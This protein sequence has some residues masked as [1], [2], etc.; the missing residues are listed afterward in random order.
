MSTISRSGA[1][2]SLA[3]LN[4]TDPV[5]KQLRAVLPKVQLSD[6]RVVPLAGGS[7]SDVHKVTWINSPSKFPDGAVLRSVDEEGGEDEIGLTKWAG[8]QGLGPN[9][10][11]SDLVSRVLLLEFLPGGPIS[12]DPDIAIPLIASCLARLHT[13]SASFV[14]TMESNSEATDVDGEES[15]ELPSLLRNAKAVGAVARAAL[16]APG[17]TGVLC[18]RD[19]HRHNMMI[20]RGGSVKLIDWTYAKV[21]HPLT[22]VALVSLFWNFTEVQEKILLKEYLGSEPTTDLQRNFRL[23]K[24]VACL[25]QLDWGLNRCEG[26]AGLYGRLEETIALSDA[27]PFSSFAERIASGEGVGT[28]PD[29]GRM[30]AVA[31]ARLLIQMG[32]EGE[33]A[34]LN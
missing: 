27:P 11:E 34:A 31:A 16:W 29:E 7:M 22:D 8:D 3:P 5:A 21:D 19:L 13:E 1:D 33:G 4:P 18:H 6:C 24:R 14:A 25:S 30:Y 32:E 12:E 10:L 17:G 15:V 2:A 20:S 26:D 23:A 9:V 28:T